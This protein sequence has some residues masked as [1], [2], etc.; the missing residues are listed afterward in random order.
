M[1]VQGLYLH[2]VQ[3]F[4]NGTVMRNFQGDTSPKLSWS[5]DW[6]IEDYYHYLSPGSDV[7]LRYTDLTQNVEAYVTEAWM[8][9]W[10]SAERGSLDPR[11]ITHRSGN[12]ALATTFVGII[13]PYECQSNIA[14]VRRVNIQSRSRKTF[15]EANVAIEVTLTDGPKDLLIAMDS[16]NPL[17]DS[18]SLSTY[19]LYSQRE[20]DVCYDA[21]LAFCAGQL[22]GQSKK[23]VLLNGLFYVPAIA[24]FTLLKKPILGSC[25]HRHDGRQLDT[26][27]HFECV[28][29]LANSL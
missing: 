22:Q 8:S 24:Q 28:C 5:V 2:P 26:A 7:H 13:E 12:S 6:K 27:L 23:I 19:K 10:L 4:T 16:E 21:N 1:T 25:E 11:I 14:S 3:D 18:P 17:Q 29:R 15:P 9:L 20:W